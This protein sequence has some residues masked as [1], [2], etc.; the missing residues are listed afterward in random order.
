M[1]TLAN[2]PVPLTAAPTDVDVLVGRR[3]MLC[4]TRTQRAGAAASGR[5]LERMRFTL[6]VQPMDRH[7]AVIEAWLES[8]DE[9]RGRTILHSTS[10]P[11]T[12]STH[13]GLIHVDIAGFDD[14]CVLALS[15]EPEGGVVYARSSLLRDGGFEAG[16]YD[17]PSLL[18]VEGRI[19]QS[20]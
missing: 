20:A 17:P 3:V 2:T 12:M 5:S 14:D 4:W 11:C 10:R 6:S 8:D 1:R 13:A 19:P 18:R 15:I 16:N 7:R 9:G